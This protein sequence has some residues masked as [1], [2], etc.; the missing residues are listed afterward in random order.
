MMHSQIS[1]LPLEW[2]QKSMGRVHCE[3]PWC[4]LGIRTG[5]G[6]RQEVKRD[7][8]VLRLGKVIQSQRIFEYAFACENPQA[9]QRDFLISAKL[10]GN[11]W[12]TEV[13]ECQNLSR[14]WYILTNCRT[15]KALEFH[16]SVARFDLFLDRENIKILRSMVHH[17]SALD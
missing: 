10:G 3:T 15:E 13:R 14:V 8:K 5:L 17:V 4:L 7:A 11:F 6:H 1:Q 16:S 9:D 2:F 12:C